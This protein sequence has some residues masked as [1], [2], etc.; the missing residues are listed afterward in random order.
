MLKNRF[1]GFSLL[2]KPQ[3]AV[4][5]GSKQTPLDVRESIF[6]SMLKM[7]AFITPAHAPSIINAQMPMDLLLFCP[8]QYSDLNSK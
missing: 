2:L 5:Y 8:E 6:N 1:G 3:L 7:G 4:C